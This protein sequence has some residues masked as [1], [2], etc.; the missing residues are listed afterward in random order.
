MTVGREAFSRAEPLWLPTL[1][2]L[3]A[4]LRAL[5]PRLA[6]RVAALRAGSLARCDRVWLNASAACPVP[7]RVIAE[8]AQALAEPHVTLERGADAHTQ[9]LGSLLEQHIAAF[10]SRYAEGYGTLVLGHNATH[11]LLALGRTLLCE[12]PELGI[13]HGVL[14]HR[15]SYMLSSL[16]GWQQR[17][18]VP[19]SETGFYERHTLTTLRADSVLLLNV[20]HHMFGTLQHDALD[21]ISP[22]VAMIADLSQAINMLPP[23]HSSRFMQR[24]FAAVFNLGKA[25]SPASVGV[26]WLRDP[27]L[28]ERVL[29]VNPELSGS[30]S[31]LT[32]KTLASAC[33][34]L[35][36]AVDDDWYA[37]VWTLTRYAMARLAELEHVSLIGCRSFETN[38]HKLGIVSLNVAG[39]TPTELGMYLDSQG[40]AVR[41][42]G[43]CTADGD[44]TREYDCVRLSLLPHITPDEI[45]ALTDALRAC[46]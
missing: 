16:P 20:L 12:Q 5:Q 25:F 24:A 26:L 32:V 15:A 23:S 29:E 46:A 19:Y 38:T 43:R 37:Y 18:L 44:S 8:L 9:Q 30:V 2:S 31:G 13:A 35:Y 17:V 3:R 40:F 7:S 41:A 4:E 36:E 11:V 34:Y 42:D 6:S 21:H 27:E 28:A 14:D 10:C 33:S 45:D 22:D 1:A 39:M